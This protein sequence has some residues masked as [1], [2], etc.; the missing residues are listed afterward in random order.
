VKIQQILWLFFGFSGRVDR[1]AFA[2]TGMLLYLARLYPVYR[3]IAAGDNEAEVSY[4]AGVLILL[5]IILIFSHIAL[6]VKRLHDFGRPGWLSI[7]FLIGD[8]FAF[9]FLCIPRS[10][11]GPNRYGQRTNSPAGAV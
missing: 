5:F 7:L 1:Q 9:L 8:I 3:M 4:W 6:A 10:D 11:N 2:L